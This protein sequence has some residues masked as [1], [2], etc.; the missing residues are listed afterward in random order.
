MAALQLALQRAR[1]V[2]IERVIQRI[3][4]ASARTRSSSRSIVSMKSRAASWL[5]CQMRFAAR[6]P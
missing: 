4:L 2:L 5:E 6:R 1:A 3:T